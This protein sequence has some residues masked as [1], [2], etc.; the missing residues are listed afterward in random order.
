M[1]TAIE[2]DKAKSG[3]QID[4]AYQNAS[5]KEPTE[6]GVDKSKMEAAELEKDPSQNALSSFIADKT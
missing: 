1:V 2:E 6:I 3:L 5:L 4:E